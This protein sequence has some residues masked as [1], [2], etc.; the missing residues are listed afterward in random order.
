M[1][2]ERTNLTRRRFMSNFAFA[3]GAIATGVGSWVVRPDWANAVEGPIKVGIATDLTGPIAFAGVADANV[4]KM[5]IKEINDNGGLLGRP[6]ELYFEDTASNESIAVGNVRKLIQRDKV[7]LVLGGVTSSMRNAIKDPIVARGKTLYIYPELYEG[8][9]CTPYLFCTGPTP[10]QQ[11]DDLIPW[12][13]KNGGKKFALPGSNYIYPHTINVYARRLIEAHGGEV[14]F[15]EYYPLD[16]VDFSA[17]VNR[18]ISNK[19]DVVFNTIIPPGVGP[20]FKQL[21][22][23]GFLKNGGRLACV[24]ADENLLNISQP[25]EIEGMASCLDY[26][27]AVT[28]SDPVSAKIQATYDRSFPGKI[29][30]AAGSAATGTWRGLKLW[31]AAVKEA[32]KVDRESVAATLDHARIAEGPGGPA[33]MVPGKRHCKMNMY[34]AVAKGGNYEIVG[35]SNGLVDPKEC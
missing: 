1:S 10:A 22:E 32:G 29:L 12:L 3:T 21:S 16:Q 5:V 4:A 23:A 25:H 35:C 24:W 11:C 17:T 34:I 6:I 19:V 26:F 7:D 15:D 33:E 14:V 27:R 30:F 9:E 13:I 20:L 18:I 31:E 2:I 8:R 28:A